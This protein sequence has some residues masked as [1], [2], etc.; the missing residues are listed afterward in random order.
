MHT[1]TPAWLVVATALCGVASCAPAARAPARAPVYESWLRRRAALDLTCTS[2]AIALTEVSED[3][4]T[5]LL[6]G[7]GHRARYEYFCFRPHTFH[8]ACGWTRR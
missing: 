6:E 2:D 3:E 4:T 1:E 8:N 5:V 7:C